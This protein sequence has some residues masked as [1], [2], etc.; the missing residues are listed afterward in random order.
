MNVGPC[1]GGTQVCEPSGLAWGACMGQV[2][3]VS[4]ICANSFDEDCNG[5]V[6]DVPDLDGDGWNACNGDCCEAPGAAC[7]SPK[8]VNPGAFEVL[9]NGVNDDC[10]AATSD[11]MA[12]PACSTVADFSAVTASD[13]AKA[14]DICQTTT[15]NPPLPQ[16]KWGLLSAAH[17]LANGNAPGAT[18]LNNMQNWQTAILQNYGT[19]MLPKKGPTMAGLSSGRMRDQNDVGFVNPPDTDHAHDSNPPLAYL[20]AHGGNL[21]GSAGCSGACASGSGANDSVAIR[22]SIRVPTNAKSF[23]Y[24]FRFISYEYDDWKCSL[25]NDFYLALLTTGAPGIPADKNISFDSLNNPVSVNNGFFDVCV[26]EGCYTCPAG[27]AELNGTGMGTTGGA[28]KW[29]TTD[30]PIVPGETMQLDLMIFDVSDNM[31]DSNALLDNFRWNLATVT[32]GTH[33]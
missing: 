22:L 1:K 4:E 10:D 26:P 6:D 30:A 11:T 17:R 3:P 27:T 18:Q 21:P 23:S 8:L 33:E 32:V 24:D 25:F 12:P 9:N 31:L 29:L 19:L 7:S 2:M 13:V 15:S 20:A 5:V 16:K 28:T 14:M